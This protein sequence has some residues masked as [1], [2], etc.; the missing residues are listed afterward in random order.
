MI[1]ES[2]Y[3]IVLCF[4][5]RNCAV[6][7]N[8]IY[9]NIKLL[10][11][12]NNYNIS[13]IFVYDNCNDKSAESLYK[14]AYNSDNINVYIEKIEN[15][16]NQRTVRIAKARNTCLDILYNKIKNVDFHIMIDCDDVNQKK[17]NVEII[18][19]YINNFDNDNWDCISFNR[20]DYF[21]IWALLIDDFKHHCWGF[22]KHSR[23][24]VSIMQKYIVSKLN[25]SNTNSIQC[26]SAFNGFAIYKT[27][28]FKDIKYDG[29]Y[30]NMHNLITDKERQ[31]TVQLCRE[32][33]QRDIDNNQ[34][35]EN[36]NSLHDC[37]GWRGECCEHIFY[38]LS[39]IQQNG[40]IIKIS[41]FKL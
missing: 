3:N 7:L 21:D 27:R 31:Q 14:Y 9:K 11:D 25:D 5:V 19:K 35:D 28:K 29:L 2:K 17:W 15:T 38:H 4:C 41:K 13:C 30:S 37:N 18:N 34:L 32:I 26:L 36:S 22:G 20:D 10:S 6:Y 33:Y 16:S 8:D 12:N 23:Y 1:N 24:I 40:C 39:A